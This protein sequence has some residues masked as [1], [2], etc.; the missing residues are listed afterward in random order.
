MH[1]IFEDI[2]VVRVVGRDCC[3]IK[4]SQAT[5]T[6]IVWATIRSHRVMDEYMRR[7]F[8]EH[9][10]ISAVIARHLASHH[11][12]PDAALGDHVNCLE[13]ALSKLMVKVDNIESRLAMVEVKNDISPKK[14]RGGGKE[15][16]QQEQRQQG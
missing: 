2:H 1:R 8:F 4:N 16:G 7:Y 3:D 13:T 9:P 14:P 5:A 12:R 11:I 6:Q 10:S 15:Q